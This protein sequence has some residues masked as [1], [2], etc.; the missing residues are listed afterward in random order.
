M[1]ALPI[2]ISWT[3]PWITCEPALP[4]QRELAAD[5]LV[6]LDERRGLAGRRRA[7]V[8]GT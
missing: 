2:G 1:I 5:E 8:S 3:L 7:D 6:G 4:E